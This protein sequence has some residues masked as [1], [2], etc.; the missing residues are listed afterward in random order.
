VTAT[1]EKVRAQDLLE[2]LR[3]HYIKPGPMPG[4]IFLAECGINGGASSQRVDAVHVGFTSASGRILT[5]HEIK[6]SRGD[7]LH[8]LDR[9]NKADRWADQCHAWYVVAP[10][11]EIVKPEELPHGWGLMVP[12][13]RTTT[14]MDIRVKAT[15]KTHDVGQHNPSWLIVRSIMA[16]YDTLRATAI[17]EARRKH[18][19]ESRREIAQAREEFAARGAA[20]S[21]P[22]LGRLSQLLARAKREGGE[23]FRF[24]SIDDD[25]VVA[26]LIDVTKLRAAAK[27]LRWD[28]AR[29]VRSTREITKPFESA[30]GA[31]AE[32]LAEIEEEQP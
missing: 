27:S 14:R 20:M 13:P 28:L 31:L 7:W 15:V 26:A 18:A 17:E 6:V 24:H 8:E 32:L 4:G 22:E 25:D 3:R 21:D 19:D 2:R 10:S 29:V 23:E 30:Y 1:V 12:N 9:S 5:G 16:R 11:V